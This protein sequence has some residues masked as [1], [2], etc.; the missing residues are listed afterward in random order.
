MPLA[1]RHLVGAFFVLGSS[2]CICSKTVAQTYSLTPSDPVRTELLAMGKAGRSIELAREKVLEILS[3]PNACSA[4][5][6]GAN[7]DPAGVF[8]SLQFAV[9]ENGPAYITASPTNSGAFFFKH[10]YS[11]SAVENAGRGALIVLNAH[12][13]FFLNSAAV[14]KQEI[15]GSAFR[16]DGWRNMEIGSYSGS[17]LSAQLVTLLHELGHVIGRIPVDSDELS[18][19]STHNTQEVVRHC[20][21]AIKASMHRGGSVRV[22]SGASANP[23]N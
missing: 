5:F 14:M 15:V 8:A 1:V 17:T 18:L 16:R 13:P 22:L 23:A 9:D 2:F 6:G 10:P 19:Q 3:E 11:G 7:P 21:H 4:W 12:G 20:R